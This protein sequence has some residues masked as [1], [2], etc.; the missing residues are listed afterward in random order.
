MMN[1]PG[2]DSH[3]FPKGFATPPSVTSDS[4]IQAV[5]NELY[6]D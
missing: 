5:W 4:V 1:S 3:D 2:T 6:F